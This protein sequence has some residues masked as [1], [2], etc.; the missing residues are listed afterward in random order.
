MIRP[1][2]ADRPTHARVIRRR[3]ADIAFIEGVRAASLD[4][5][6]QMAKDYRRGPQWKRVAIAR[7][8][9]MAEGGT[10]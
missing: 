8:I 10:G 9:K 7:R 4:D 2:D 3:E 6:R 5:L 1:A